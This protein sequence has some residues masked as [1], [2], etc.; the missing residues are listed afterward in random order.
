MHRDAALHQSPP[1]KGLV[2]RGFQFAPVKLHCRHAEAFAGFVWSDVTDTLLQSL[3]FFIIAK[4][5]KIAKVGN[6]TGQHTRNTSREHLTIHLQFAHSLI[7]TSTYIM[8]NSRR[9][10]SLSIIIQL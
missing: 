10:I 6:K 4:H 2:S 9:K 3:F 8:V 7:E 1:D 5:G